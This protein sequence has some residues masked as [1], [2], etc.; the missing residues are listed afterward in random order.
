MSAG[1]VGIRRRLRT[2][3]G[4]GDAVARLQSALHAAGR[5]R[6]RPGNRGRGPPAAGPPRPHRRR[7]GRPGDVE[8]ARRCTARKRSPRRPRRCPAGPPP[9]RATRAPAR[10]ALQRER[11]VQRG[12]HGPKQR[13]AA[14]P[15]SGCSSA[16]PPRRRRIRS[17]DRGGGPPP[18]GPPRPDRRRRRRPGDVERAR[19]LTARQRSPRPAALRGSARAARAARPAAPR[20]GEGEASERRRAGDRGRR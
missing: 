17:R 10:Q 14:T 1:A 18:S 16:A 8:R 15:C 13:P 2:G 9:A 4:S 12:L 11:R 20:G 3:A 5:R 19:H 7:R 6:L